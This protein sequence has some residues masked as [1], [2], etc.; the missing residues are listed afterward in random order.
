MENRLCIQNENAEIRN[1]YWY[2]HEWRADGEG[3]S[4]GT[5]L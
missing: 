5:Y 4:K 3:K 1:L 2:I